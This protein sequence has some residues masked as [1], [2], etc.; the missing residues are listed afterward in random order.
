M[1]TALLVLAAVAAV[2]DWMAVAQ[3]RVR[4]ERVLKPLTLA[5]L[6]AAAAIASFGPAQPWMV[7]ALALSLVGDVALLRSEDTAFLVGLAAFLLGHVC[8]LV[9]FLR[10]GVQAVEVVI[11]ATVVVLVSALA[12]PRLL[13]GAAASAG[14]GFAAAV[15]AYAAV[16]GA[17]TALGVGT[18]VVV[19]A[20]GAVLFLASDTV[21]AWQR[22]VVAV[23]NGPLVVIVTYH[24]ASVLIPT[25]NSACAEG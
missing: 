21:L 6:L 7:A 8:Y 4:A 3:R 24:V 15:A 16:L 9:A 22:F 18:G 2:A 23:R 14:I 12:L 5:L 17:M 10:V 20:L 13:R 1:S 11:G 19:T 25:G